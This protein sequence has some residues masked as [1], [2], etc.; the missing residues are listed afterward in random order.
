[1]NPIDP[2][3]ASSRKYHEEKA[4]SLARRI[5]AG[6]VELIAGSREMWRIGANIVPDTRIDRDFVVFL[7]LDSETDALPLAKDRALWDPAAF[8]EQSRIVA[9][10]EAEE[11]P[12]VY[13]ACRSIIDRFA[14]QPGS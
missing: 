6:E 5:V 1:M 4:V 10:I 7:A 13:A 3:E 14:E 9:D 12:S 2:G 8:A 11:R